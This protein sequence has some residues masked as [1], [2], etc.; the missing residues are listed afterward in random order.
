M[1]GQVID[2][3]GKTIAFIPVR[4]GSTSI[5][6][7]NIKPMCG[8]PLLY[9]TA[10]A[11]DGC[12]FIDEVVIATDSPEIARVAGSMGLAKVRVVGRGAETATN[13]ATK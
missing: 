9:W 7:K 1:D 12:R 6:L 11:A 13:T 10:A 5:P 3:M 8:K 2:I 4:G